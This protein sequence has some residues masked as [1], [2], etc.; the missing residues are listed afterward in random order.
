MSV[1]VSVQ[2]NVVQ[3]KSKRE[4][5]TG[6]RRS[7]FIAAIVANGVLL[8]VVNALPGWNPAFITGSFPAVLTPVNLSLI[9]Q[10]VGYFALLFYHP[11]SLYHAA[12]MVF[13]GFS[14]SA[15]IAL[16]TVFPFDFSGLVGP[17]L[18]TVLRVTFVIG[19]V[20]SAI[21]AVVNLVKLVV[22]GKK[23]WEP[24]GE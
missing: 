20:G 18:N 1:K 22:A 8:F 2:K 10:I 16:V 9:A 15:L 6:N 13:D 5:D 17:W 3:N 11:Q 4:K 24:E 14:I 7:A 12:K 21:S 23:E 19:I